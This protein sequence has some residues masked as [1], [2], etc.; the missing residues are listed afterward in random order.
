[1]WC[2]L[3]RFSPCKSLQCLPAT[4]P[5]T[6]LDHSN[7]FQT[8]LSWT[9]VFSAKGSG[10]LRRLFINICNGLQPYSVFIGWQFQALTTR[11][12]LSFIIDNANRINQRHF[13]LWQEPI[14]QT[15]CFLSLGWSVISLSLRSGNSWELPLLETES[16]T[17]EKLT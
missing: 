15:S 9:A 13:Q 6:G 8:V 1:M 2:R 14:I 12:R 10:F 5:L 17:L 16:H 4:V 11:R 3:Q 7:L